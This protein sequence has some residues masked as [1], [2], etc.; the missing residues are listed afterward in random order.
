MAATRG[1][2]PPDARDVGYHAPRV[3]AF[4]FR[5]RAG[6]QLDPITFDNSFDRWSLTGLVL[7]DGHH[8]LIAAAVTRHTTVSCSYSGRVDLLEWLE[9][10]RRLR[11]PELR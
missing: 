5:L 8:R 11:P 3:L 9:G 6:E 2:R 4:V 10:K 1:W 7:I